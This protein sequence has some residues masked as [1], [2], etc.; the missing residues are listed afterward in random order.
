MMIQ[1]FGENVEGVP[2]LGRHSADELEVSALDLQY[3]VT[4][5]QFPRLLLRR[6]LLRKRRQQVVYCLSARTSN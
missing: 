5:D 2:K 4:R 6:K 3:A 1:T